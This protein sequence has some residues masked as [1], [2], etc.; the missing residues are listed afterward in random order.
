[1]LPPNH[2]DPETREDMWEAAQQ[3]GICDDPIGYEEHVTLGEGWGR[4]SGMFAHVEC[5]G[6]CFY[7]TERAIHF[8]KR[9]R[10]DEAPILLVCD[11]CHPRNTASPE[12]VD[13]S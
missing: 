1:M 9:D 10:R 4:E 6:K 2:L 7:C 11:Q 12:E 13:E 3:C 5:L 8:I